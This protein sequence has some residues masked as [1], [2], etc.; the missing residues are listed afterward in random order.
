MSEKALVKIVIMH[1]VSGG[2]TAK[3][4][5][6]YWNTSDDTGWDLIPE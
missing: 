2:P 6:M 3:Q 4:L 5:I 1:K